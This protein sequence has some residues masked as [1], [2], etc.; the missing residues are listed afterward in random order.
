MKLALALLLFALGTFALAQGTPERIKVHGKSL[1]GNLSADPAIRDVS[2]YLPP[3][4]KKE[5]NRRYPVVYFLHGFTDSDQKWFWEEK[6]WINLPKVLDRALAEGAAEM[7]VVMPNAFTLFQGSM[8]SNSV[9]TGDWE[10]YVARELVAYIDSHYRTL[11]RRESR[12]I[13][14][15]SMGG[16]GTL[17]IGMKNPDVFSALYALS[18]CCMAPG[19][20]S[21]GPQPDLSHV[22]TAEDVAKLNFFQKASL[23]GAAAWSPNPQNPPLYLDLAPRDGNV[24][25]DLMARWAA[26]APLAFVDQYIT[27]LKRYKGIGFDAGDQ[28]AVIG[29]DAKAFSAKLQAYGLL[30]DFEIYPGNHTNHIDERIVKK[31][32]PFFTRHLEAGKKR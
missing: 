15:H 8:Y 3:S 5:K 29:R 10:S 28:E 30:H 16:Y 2:V 14:G 4:Y 25:P 32:M 7:I 17:R 18:P 22:R 24:P 12:G 20:T 1:E 9:T 23:A 11:P 31:T 6:H 26:N 13:A 27:H 21:R 19:G